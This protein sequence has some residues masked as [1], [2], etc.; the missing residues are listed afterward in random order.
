MESA[1]FTI[2]ICGQMKIHTILSSH[3][4]LFSINIWAGIC[5]D[6]IFRPHILPNRLT[7]WN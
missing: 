3:Q 5:D 6:N 1:I 2:S 4:Q 7:G